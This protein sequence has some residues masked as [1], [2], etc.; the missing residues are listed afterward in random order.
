[1]GKGKVK[2][3]ETVSEVLRAAIERSGLSLY[4]VAKNAGVGYTTLHRFMHRERSLSM[5]ALDKLCA[6]LGLELQS[7][8]G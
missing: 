3:A 5:E 4:R 1:M 2:Q 6:S 7:K 8:K